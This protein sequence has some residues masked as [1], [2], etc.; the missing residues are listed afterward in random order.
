MVPSIAAAVMLS[1]GGAVGTDAAETDIA[2]VAT[3]VRQRGYACDRPQSLRSDL[4]SSLPDRPAW[5]IDCEQGR[6]RVT[7]EGDTGARVTPLR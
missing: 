5:I 4:Q 6:F 3:A 1:A 2:I 7:F